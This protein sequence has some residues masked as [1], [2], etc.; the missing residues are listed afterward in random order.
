M[1]AAP[2]ISPK[3][4][5]EYTPEDFHAYVSNMF[6]MR[7]K[8]TSAKPTSGV[9]GL[10]VS[11]TKKGAL[12]LRRAKSRTFEY[13][14]M[15]ELVKLATHAKASQ[16]EVWNLFKT[17]KYIISKDRMEAEQIYAQIKEIPWG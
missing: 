13:V 6:S 11:R 9:L 3:P 16:A 2:H 4:F 7:T 1:S 12:S 17:K 15:G 14:T 10:V 5:T 8:K